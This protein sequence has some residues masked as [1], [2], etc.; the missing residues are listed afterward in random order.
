MISLGGFIIT[1]NRPE[2]L[3]D[4]I[5]KVFEQTH[6]PEI[7]WIIDNSENLRTDHMIASLLDSRIKYHRMGYNAGPAGAAAVGLELCTED[8]ADWIYWGDDNDPPFRLDCFQRLLAIRDVNPYCGV[9]GAVGHFF[10][11]KKGVIKRIQTRLLEKKEWIPV[12]TIAGGMCMIV[13]KD[14]VKAKIFPDK[15]LFFGFEE[16]DFCLKASRKGFALVVDCGLF[17]ESRK[18]SGRLI[19]A[20]PAYQKKSNLNREYY[21]L[22]NLLFISDSL[23]L[24][25]MKRKL[26]GKWILKAFYGYRYG[27]GYGWKNMRLIFLA[28]LHYYGGVKGKTIDLA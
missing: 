28:L 7:L 1:Y 20:R 8:G 12:D 17:L 27:L 24:N 18:E 25:T 5:A 10:D 13:S 15:D 14:V 3:K 21:S 22:R 16:L 23:T 11:R 9:L 26:I 19:F 4:T 2:I 6:P